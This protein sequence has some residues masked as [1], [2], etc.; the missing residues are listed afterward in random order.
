MTR[1]TPLRMAP[2]KLIRID[3]SPNRVAIRRNEHE[4][5]NCR[6]SSPIVNGKGKSSHRDTNGHAFSD[7]YSGHWRL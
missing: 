5:C 6:K 4:D 1:L 3:R 7:E 2:A